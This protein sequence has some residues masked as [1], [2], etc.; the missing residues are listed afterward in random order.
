MIRNNEMELSIKVSTGIP[1]YKLII[2]RRKKKKKKDEVKRDKRTRSEFRTE[3]KRNLLFSFLE[4]GVGQ[5]RH[6]FERPRRMKFEKRL[7]GQYG[8]E[9]QFSTG[10]DF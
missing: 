8:I 10:D 6:I 4:K 1:T 7:L 9:Q 3:K 2:V 5:L